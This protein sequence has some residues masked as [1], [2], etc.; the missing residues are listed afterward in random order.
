MAAPNDWKAEAIKAT[1]RWLP[2]IR[3]SAQQRWTALGRAVDGDEPGWLVLDKRGESIRPESLND[4]CFAADGGPDTATTHPVEQFRQADE[5]L[6]LKEP[7]ALPKN[8]RIVWTKSMSERFLVERL[9][10]GLRACGDT[11]IADAF[12]AGTLV[13]RAAPVPAP[14]GLTAAQVE[15]YRSCLT[16]GVRVVWGPPGTGKTRVLS[17]AIE[18]LIKSGARVLLVSTANIAVDN[19]LQAVV[20]AKRPARGVAVRVGPPHLAELVTNPDVHLEQLAAAASHQVDRE[21]RA[22]EERLAELDALDQQVTALAEQVGGF[23]PA[24]FEAARERIA[25]RRAAEKLALDIANVECQ[26]KTVTEMASTA[27]SHCSR[28]RPTG[29]T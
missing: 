7:P 18:D 9:L 28:Q 17:R 14:P 26:W 19:A 21:L 8:S 1:E 12:A 24:S 11:P 15:A 25:N 29:R 2:L 4:L 5:L 20:Q 13:T 22:I 10:D 16:P 23:D 27:H 6:M 3:G